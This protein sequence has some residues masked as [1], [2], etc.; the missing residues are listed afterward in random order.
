MSRNARTTLQKAHRRWALVGWLAV[1]GSLPAAAGLARA[2][3]ESVEVPET[4]EEKLALIES[5]AADF[6]TVIARIEAL[7]LGTAE[8]PVGVLTDDARTDTPAADP[9]PKPATGLRDDA[10]LEVERAALQSEVAAHPVLSELSDDQRHAVV[11]AAASVLEGRFKAMQEVLITAEVVEKPAPVKATGSGSSY[12][13]DDDDYDNYRA[14]VDGCD[15]RYWEC[16]AGCVG[17]SADSVFFSSPLSECQHFCGKA[18][19]SCVQS[20]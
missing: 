12:S 14:C 19:N 8:A 3:D 13:A 15:S 16:K 1:G 6:D 7:D 10:R 18:E 2:N 4:A 9:E 17:L 11:A 5:L 20:C